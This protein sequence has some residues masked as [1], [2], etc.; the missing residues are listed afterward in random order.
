MASEN[1]LSCAVNCVPMALPAHELLK[2]IDPRTEGG[3]RALSKMGNKCLEQLRERHAL[4]KKSRWARDFRTRVS[5]LAGT[6]VLLVVSIGVHQLLENPVLEAT[7]FAVALGNSALALSLAIQVRRTQAQNTLLD[8]LKPMSEPAEIETAWQL[9]QA[10]KACAAY[11]SGSNLRR[12]SLIKADLLA[13]KAL[14][15]AAGA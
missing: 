2:T 6:S 11:L 5:A 13:L 10:S 14:Q 7:V 15:S 8:L 3:R 4:P 1:A 12:T 9:A